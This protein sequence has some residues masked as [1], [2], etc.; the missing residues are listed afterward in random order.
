MYDLRKLL[1]YSLCLFFISCADDDIN[2]DFQGPVNLESKEL[3]SPV[4]KSTIEKVLLAVNTLRSEGCTCG[5]KVLGPVN[6][7]KLNNDLESSVAM[8]RVSDESILYITD[9]ASS[10][11]YENGKAIN[12][13]SRSE[14]MDEM[15][16]TWLSNPENCIMVMDA[17]YTE[18]RVS[19][20]LAQILAP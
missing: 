1:I 19:N 9:E 8:S 13:D 6:V 14:Q 11:V 7:L 16:N 5:D 10:R 20:A 15:I 3:D 17:Q 18:L 12:L 4:K 2:P